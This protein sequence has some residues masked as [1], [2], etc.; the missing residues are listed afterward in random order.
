MTTQRHWSRV[1]SSKAPETVSWYQP[2]P[3]R[4]LALIQQAVLSR[5]ARVLDVGGG[6]SFLVDELLDAGFRHVGV[7]DIAR[8]PLEI[9][10]RRL[11]KLSTDVEWIVADVTA[12]RPRHQW[13]VWHDRAVFHFL[14]DDEARAGYRH[15]LAEGL[16]PGGHA[17]VATF[18]PDGP[19]TCSGLPVERYDASGL[20]GA[21]GGDLVLESSLLDEHRTPGGGAQQ[22]LYCRFVRPE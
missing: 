9:V 7:L 13:D 6:T 18:G 1:H 22:F 5:D 20:Q 16:A 17:V 21:L 19:P 14:V 15:A 10:R 4:S 3:R 8:E 11:G 12:F 2:S